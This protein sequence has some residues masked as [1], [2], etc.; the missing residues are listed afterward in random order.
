VAA[1]GP[2]AA[3][4]EL[5]VAE[6]RVGCDDRAQAVLDARL[7]SARSGTMRASAIVP[8]PSMA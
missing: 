8:S 7:V 2:L 3:E 1:H 5:V 4:L 6:R